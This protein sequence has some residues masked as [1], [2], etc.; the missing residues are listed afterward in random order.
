MQ[1]ESKQVLVRVER[2]VALFVLDRPGGRARAELDAELHDIDPEAVSA[3][4]SSLEG[5]GVVIVE[6]EKVRASE[7]IR[8]LDALNLISA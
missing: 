4:L 7:C 1:P 5:E 2:I 6:G 3:A 8:H